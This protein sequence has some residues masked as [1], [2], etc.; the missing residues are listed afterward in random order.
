MHSTQCALHLM[1][2]NVACSSAAYGVNRV[3]RRGSQGRMHATLLANMAPI[4]W[5]GGQRVQ[6]ALRLR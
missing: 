6:I 2:L 3:Q 4:S 1:H 5:L